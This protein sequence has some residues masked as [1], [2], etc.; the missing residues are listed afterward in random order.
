MHE[1]VVQNHRCIHA[2]NRLQSV[3][4]RRWLISMRRRADLVAPR[5]LQAGDLW[6]GSSMGFP[7][8]IDG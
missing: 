8:G 3:P 7:I 6:E 5:R 2:P 1:L 4:I